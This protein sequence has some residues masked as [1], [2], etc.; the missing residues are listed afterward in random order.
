MTLPLLLL[1]A[2]LAFVASFTRHRKASGVIA[3]TTLCLLLLAGCG[4]LPRWL[5][6]IV[7]PAAA[8]PGQSIQWS[9]RPAIIVIGAGLTHESG[10][11]AVSLPVWTGGRLLR[12]VELYSACATIR[13][14]CTLF[15]SGGGSGRSGDLTE[16]ELMADQLERLGVD[17]QDLVLEPLS[18]NTWQ[19]AEFTAPLLKEHRIDGR[20]LLLT[21]A[22]HARRAASYFR[23]VGIDVEPIATDH[24]AVELTWLPSALNLAITDLALHEG[25][26]MARLRVYTALGLND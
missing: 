15:L 26:G 14:R 11:A 5:L 16:A 6:G 21:S 24:F 20:P 7:Q 23:A 19:N 8:L 22:I 9:D 3:V 4:P 10:A 18:E 25:V 1:V 17:R 13:E 12:A 2:V